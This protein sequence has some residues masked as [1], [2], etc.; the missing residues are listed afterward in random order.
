MGLFIVLI[1]IT[2]MVPMVFS[3]EGKMGLP[4]EVFIKEVLDTQ[5]ITQC[6]LGY[7]YD[8]KPHISNTFIEEALQNR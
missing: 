4:I 2:L 7:L 8:H 1:V 6:D 5:D 3:L